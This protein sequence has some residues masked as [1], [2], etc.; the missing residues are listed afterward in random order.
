[1]QL[2]YARA[3][4]V[5]RTSS[6]YTFDAASARHVGA[7]AVTACALGVLIGLYAPA[8]AA[9]LAQLA[10][11]PWTVPRVF[12]QPALGGYLVAWGTFHMLEFVITAYFNGTRL[13][14]DSFL[15]TNGVEYYIAH[16]AG[17]VE[18]LLE[19]SLAPQWKQSRAIQST[20]LLVIVCGQTLRSLAMVHAGSN[21]SHAVARQKKADHVLVKSGVYSYVD[22]PHA[23]DRSV[24]RHPSYAGFFYWAVG[25]QLLLMNPFT[26]VLF[27]L[28]LIRFFARRIAGTSR[29]R[30]LG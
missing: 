15:L 10:R 30:S 2:L 7:V 13:M 21:F 17:L 18:F 29:V 6:P 23:A 25:T 11:V 19:A 4:C 20:A 14:S 12:V 26:T 9:L 24:A 3:D 27:G 28:F 1:M 5:L 8:A 22:A 16:T